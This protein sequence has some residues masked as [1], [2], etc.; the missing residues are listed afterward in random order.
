MIFECLRFVALKKT[1]A[2]KV[3][4]AILKMSYARNLKSEMPSK[5]N[6]E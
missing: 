1:Y 4:T 3:Y 2:T 6:P 5:R